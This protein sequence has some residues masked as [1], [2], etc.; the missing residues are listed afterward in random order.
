MNVS[1]NTTEITNDLERKYITKMFKDFSLE[2]TPI[3]LSKIVSLSEFIR[4]S[5]TIYITFLPGTNYEETVETAKKIRL[6]GFNPAPHFA[7]RSIASKEILEDYVQ[8]VTGE[9]GVKKILIVAGAG[10]SQLG[11]YPDTISLLETGIFDKYGITEIGVAGHPEG[12]PDISDKEISKALLLKNE[13]ANRTDASFFIISQFCFDSKTVLNWAK[14]INSEGNKLPIIIGI[15]GVAKLSTLLKYSIACGIG[16]SMHFL[17]K[18]GSKMINLIKTQFP[19]RL[20]RELVKPHLDEI[21]T[22]IEGLHI[23]PLGGLRQSAEWAYN[24]LDGHFQLTKDGF[25]VLEELSKKQN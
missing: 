18:K 20:V 16:N 9:A 21:E 17:R 24:T 15:P 10:K 12:S 25:N 5:T 2:V 19:D 14:N 23:Y 8:R 1:D 22:G 4:P 6:A 11:P 7:A 13:I 3:G